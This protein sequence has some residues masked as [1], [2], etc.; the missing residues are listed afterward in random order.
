M[1]SPYRSPKTFKLKPYQSK[2]RG[3]ERVRT[4]ALLLA[5]AFF[6]LYLTSVDGLISLFFAIF[7]GWSGIRNI[8]LG[9]QLSK[10]PEK[11]RAYRVSTQGLFK[12]LEGRE[13]ARLDLREVRAIWMNADQ[14]QLSLMTDRGVETIQREELA[15]A[16]EWEIFTTWLERSVT[17]TIYRDDPRLWEELQKQSLAMSKLGDRTLVGSK[18][19]M[20]ALLVGAGLFFYQMQ[21]HLPFFVQVGRSELLSNVMGAPSAYLLSLG[22][23]HRLF[24]GLMIP[25]TGLSL[26]YD[27]FVL[28]WVGRSLEQLWGTWRVAL[29]YF[30]GYL[31]GCLTLG[32]L[33]SHELYIGAHG[34][35]LALCTSAYLFQGFFSRTKMDMRSMPEL[36]RRAKVSAFILLLIF[37]FTL[38]FD[39]YPSSA[40][41]TSWFMSAL[42]GALCG[43]LFGQQ[44][45]K[46]RLW[47]LREG[48]YK[49]GLI[50]I[51]GAAI[52]VGSLLFSLLT[53]N[54][55]FEQLPQEPITDRYSL[56]A[57][58]ELAQRCTG[59]PVEEVSPLPIEAI[60]ALPE[61][62]RCP[63]EYR[64]EINRVLG[65][66]IGFY[67][68]LSSDSSEAAQRAHPQSAL[69]SAFH[70]TMALTWFDTM[71]ADQLIMK[72]QRAAL[73]YPQDIF[74]DLLAAAYS[75]VAKD[76]VTEGH[77]GRAELE[78]LVRGKSLQLK[79]DKGQLTWNWGAEEE[80]EQARQRESS[81][82]KVDHAQKTSPSGSE[83]SPQETE[84]SPQET[85]ESPQETEESPQET[86]ESPQESDLIWVKVSSNGKEPSRIVVLSLPGHY[87][88]KVHRPHQRRK[89]IFENNVV[90][91]LE[92][93]D[94]QRSISDLPQRLVGE[95][96]RLYSW[97]KPK[98]LTAWAESRLQR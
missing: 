1:S 74:G 53:V 82:E 5:F 25:S 17:E 3:R 35:S 57:Q 44:T 69:V 6:N 33:S 68:R 38:G 47:V 54:T 16:S 21:F 97:S 93:I 73:N 22:E 90:G 48:G 13:L 11:N 4:G 41:R 29:I 52:P 64:K 67:P 24:A 83:E 81:T 43:W 91:E 51:M 19:L 87:N 20:L 56:A 80:Q 71:S 70:R 30:V 34:G 46:T 75:A 96:A 50:S 23:L 42:S 8:A 92:L 59:A 86:E 9:L 60:E 28:W 76:D 37:V 63:D 89:R 72:L 36:L 10:A 12:V 18:M 27:L 66:V 95:R 84:E 39:V 62:K 2:T 85:E 79:I 7:F 88:P 94:H 31:V 77:S 14:S 45:K 32:V 26:I 55:A 49:S 40:L 15:L 78:V 98:K 65:Q 61:V 58:I